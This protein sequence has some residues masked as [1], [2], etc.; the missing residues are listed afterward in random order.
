MMRRGEGFKDMSPVRR[1][2]AVLLF[3]VSLAVV[4]AAER[5]IQRRDDS[6]LR[7]NKLIWRLLSLN[8]LGALS[9]FRWGRV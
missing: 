3:L 8:A 7:G 1:V 4:V 6:Q 2:V 5:D 9:Y